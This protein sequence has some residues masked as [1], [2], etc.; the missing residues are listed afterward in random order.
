MHNTILPLA[1]MVSALDDAV[2]HVV[3]ALKDSE[4]YNNTIIVFTTDVRMSFFWF[5]FHLE[6]IWL[7]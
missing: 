4:L 3:D 6:D 5:Y 2:A 7:W 1:G